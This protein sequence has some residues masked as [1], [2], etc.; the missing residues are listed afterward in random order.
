M[1]RAPDAVKFFQVALNLKYSSTRVGFFL[2]WIIIS[3]IGGHMAAIFAVLC[4]GFMVLVL[5]TG[6]I[7]PF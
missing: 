7:N 3:M 4:F 2:P 1:K 5:M 6:L